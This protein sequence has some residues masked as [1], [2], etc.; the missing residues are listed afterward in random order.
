[1][2]IN[3]GIL[4]TAHIAMEAVIPAMLKSKYCSITAIASRSSKKA[5]A[6]AQQ[7]QIPKHYGTYQAL[8]NDQEIE[9]VYI[10]LPNHLHVTWAIKA[11]QAGKHVLLEKPIAL[12]SV[13]A[14]LLLKE[15]NKYPKL[16]LMEAF[17]YK[18]HPQ[19]IA[20]KEMIKNG[21]IG[22][23]KM[24]QSAF[25]FFDDDPTSI[26]NI[27]KY[28]GGSLMDVGCY[29]ISIARFLFDA[30]PKSVAAKIV[31][32]PKFEVDILA[33]GMLEFEQGYAN[34]FS[35][36]QMTD[37]QEVHIFGTVGSIKME[38]PFNPPTD[39]A[40]KIE[41]LKAEQKKEIYFEITDQYTLQAEYFSLAILN[42]TTIQFR[43][44][45]SICNM[46]VI[47]KLIESDR[48]GGW[49]GI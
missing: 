15:S 23:L 7:F 25:S 49:V 42:D 26:V 33:S 28:G 29:P 35:G 44:E 41:L 48:V 30:E 9:A 34:F 4:S 45:D 1:M 13:E 8:L 18:H 40:T 31:Y 37:H 14:Q 17:M 39:Q 22:E 21:D 38:L 46:I 2:K 36:I 5:K 19:W 10:P 3:W 16:K 27:K 20:V 43:L 47:E 24:I 11:L 12:S 6:A 32:H